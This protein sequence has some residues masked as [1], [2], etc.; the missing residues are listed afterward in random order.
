MTGTAIASRPILRKSGAWITPRAVAQAHKLWLAGVSARQIAAELGGVCSH[1]AVVSF[2]KRNGWP[3][4]PSPIVRKPTE[5]VA[6]AAKSPA[7][8]KRSPAVRPLAIIAVPPPARTCQWVLQAGKRGQ[9]WLFCG[10]PAVPGRSWCTD[11]MRIVFPAVRRTRD[12]LSLTWLSRP[13]A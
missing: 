10:A 7:H 6:A 2:A 12:H 3:G 1:C 11:H 9:G 13:V 5:A 8:G 4:R